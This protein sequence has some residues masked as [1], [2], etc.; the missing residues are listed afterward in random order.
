MDSYSSSRHASIQR[1]AESLWGMMQRTTQCPKEYL[2]FTLTSGGIQCVCRESPTEN[3]ETTGKMVIKTTTP[4]RTWPERTV[5]TRK[6]SNFIS[7]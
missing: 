4:R 2:I 7:D 1:E 3:V 6:K 5:S